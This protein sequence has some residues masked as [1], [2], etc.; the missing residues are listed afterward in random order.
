[1]PI[2]RYAHLAFVSILFLD[3]RPQQITSHTHVVQSAPT[4]IGVKLANDTHLTIAAAEQHANK[5]IPHN[6]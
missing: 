2:Q 3:Q 6:K 5:T 4:N 1:M